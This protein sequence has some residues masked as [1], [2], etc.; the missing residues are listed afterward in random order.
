[1]S[2]SNGVFFRPDHKTY[3]T[4]FDDNPIPKPSERIHLLWSICFIF[5]GVKKIG[6]QK[7]GDPSSSP[8]GYISDVRSLGKEVFSWQ[9]IYPS[10]PTHIPSEERF[11][12]AMLSAHR[13]G[14]LHKVAEKLATEVLA[15]GTFFSWEF[16]SEFLEDFWDDSWVIVCNM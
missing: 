12:V 4:S 2:G 9:M 7:N 14:E 6:Y 16:F 3:S 15:G 11:K 10:H 8:S 1:M 5:L 13:T